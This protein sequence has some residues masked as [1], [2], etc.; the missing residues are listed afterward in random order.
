MKKVY[1]F[2]NENKEVMNSSSGGAFIAICKTFENVFGIGMVSYYG[3]TYDDNMNVVHKRV[4]TAEQCHIFQGSKYVKSNH[5]RVLKEI[6]LDVENKKKILFSGTPCQ[7]F[8][9]KNYL[10]A[11]NVTYDDIY[12]ID[13][14]CHGTPQVKIWEDYKRWLEAKHN[15]KLI[16]YSFRYKPEGWK[17]YP[18]YAKFENGKKLINTAETSIYSKLHMIGYITNKG[19]FSCPYA[20]ENREGDITLGDYWG[21]EKVLPSF[22]YKNGVS[23]IILNS[24]KMNKIVNNLV[25]YNC[26]S[27][28]EE[29]KSDLYIKYQHNLTKQTEKPNNYDNFWNDY[30]TNGFEYVLKKYL[31]YGLKYKIIFKI[32]KLVRKTPLIDMYR[33]FKNK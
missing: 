5:A 6:E 10:K 2:K 26:E 31:G 4:D 16:K 13:I 19:C 14:I 22:S 15:S 11:K 9:V 27:N 8:A 18:A 17:A 29:T 7:V 20:T 25:K 28:L 1:A 24:N 30:E 33:H 23:L 12:Y 21:I 32:K 3:A